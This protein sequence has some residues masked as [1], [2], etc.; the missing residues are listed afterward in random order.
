MTERMECQFLM[1][2]GVPAAILALLLPSVPAAERVHSP[3]G[4]AAD[5]GHELARLPFYMVFD[6]IAFHVEGGTVTLSGQVTRPTLKS[7]MENAVRRLA[8]VRQV[9]D[10]IEVLPDSAADQRLRLAEFLAIYGDPELNQYANQ[11]AP[12]IHIVVKN[13]DVT[14]EGSVAT[15]SDKTE[16]FVRASGVPGVAS[17]TDHLRIAP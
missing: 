10:N 4:I 8:G 1:R 7:D 9:I 6:H 2:V 14:L 3:N 11:P 13:G 17:L 16:A 5:I 12:P 15:E